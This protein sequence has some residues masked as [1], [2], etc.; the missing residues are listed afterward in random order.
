MAQIW[1]DCNELAKDID[2]YRLDHFL[3]LGSKPVVVVTSGGFDCLH[4]GH[5]RCLLETAKLGDRTIAI[6]NGDGFLMRKKGH[7]MMTQ[8]ERLEIIS[9]IRGID[10]V[11]LFD[12]GT[13]FVA[14]ALEILRPQVFAKGG[15]RSS[16]AQMATCE[17]ETCARIGCRIMYGIGGVE[18]VQSSSWLKAKWMETNAGSQAGRLG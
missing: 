3:L 15:D 10:D 11:L 5:V 8:D 6:V 13:Q 1:T 12:D 9:A 16:P 4:V 7:V 18:K 17:L 2:R 14:G